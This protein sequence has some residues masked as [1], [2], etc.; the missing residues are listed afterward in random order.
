M[1]AQETLLIETDK[2]RY[3]IGRFEFGLE[4]TAED[5]LQ[6]IKKIEEFPAQLKKVATGLTEQQL[7][8]TY[9]E[10]GWNVRQIIHHVADSHM[11]AYTRFKLTL[12]EDTPAIKPYDEKAWAELED[13]KN[14]IAFHFDRTSHGTSQ[15]LVYSFKSMTPE[16][17]ELRFLSPGTPD[18]P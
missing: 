6:F 16:Q 5:M 2:L 8:D 10:G 9:R 12:T 4:Y 15:A 1:E 18:D 14:C 3:P 7:D 17:F 11:N 13:A